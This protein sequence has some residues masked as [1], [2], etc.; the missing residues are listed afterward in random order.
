MRARKAPRPL[1]L[2]GISPF[3]LLPV[4]CS[5][6]PIE[7][8]TFFIFAIVLMT[9]NLSFK[10]FFALG[11]KRVTEGHFPENGRNQ[12]FSGQILPFPAAKWH[13]FC[14]EMACPVHA[15]AGEF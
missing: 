5:S 1:P 8:K 13:V 12:P 14:P 9:K 11:N 10:N 6:D 3:S 4:P 2:V 15:A 7:R